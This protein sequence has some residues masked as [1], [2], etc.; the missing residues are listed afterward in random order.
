MLCQ[1]PRKT[2][3]LLQRERKFISKTEKNTACSSRHF[4]QLD[5]FLTFNS[6]NPGNLLSLLLLSSFPFAT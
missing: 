1:L 2:W 5:E 4:H 6:G 3:S